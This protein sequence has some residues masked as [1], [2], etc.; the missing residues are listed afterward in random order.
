MRIQISRGGL[1]GIGREFLEPFEKRGHEGAD[2]MC[3]DE[4]RVVG[5]AGAEFSE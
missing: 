4:L 1:A 2:E 3:G 5:D